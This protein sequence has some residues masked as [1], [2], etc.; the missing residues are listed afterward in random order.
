MD[1]MLTN[2]GYKRAASERPT[3]LCFFDHSTPWDQI[4][5]KTLLYE[6]MILEINHQMDIRDRNS[7]AIIKYV[8]KLNAGR[9]EKQNVT[10]GFPSRYHWIAGEYILLSTAEELI[11][12]S[13][14]KKN[15]LENNKLLWTLLLGVSSKESPLSL[16]K[17]HTK[18]ILWNIHNLV[19]KEMR[20]KL[21][22]NVNDAYRY[23]FC[24][25]LSFLP[26]LY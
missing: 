15:V 24:I 18:T 20:S 6:D 25:L 11:V 22:H 7:G 16:L 2:F 1:E 12:T 3:L 23:F 14:R 8:L 9:M 26:F 5:Q 21:V 4:A 19:Q 10:L 13:L 17:G